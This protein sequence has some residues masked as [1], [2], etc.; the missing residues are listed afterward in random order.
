LA[1]RYVLA[2][3]THGAIRFHADHARGKAVSSMP[4]E[5]DPWWRRFDDLWQESEVCSPGTI[6]GL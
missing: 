1:D 4:A 2:D 5:I 6:T 3:Q